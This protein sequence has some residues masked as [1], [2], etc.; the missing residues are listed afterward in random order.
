MTSANDRLRRAREA[1]SSPVSPGVPM[2]RDELA[3]AV[4]TWL[5]Q[6][7]DAG[8]EYAFDAHHLG[9]LERGAV[10]RPHK[11]LR[12]AL[13]AVLQR[14][15]HEL[16]FTPNADGERPA[17]EVS[18]L[19]R[20]DAVRA[21]SDVLA[22][23]RRQ[24]DALG[25]YDVLPAALQQ[26]TIA[27]RIADTATYDTRKRSVSL[28][29]NVENY[30]GWLAL[31]LDKWAESRTH[32]DRAALLAVEA[33]DPMRLSSALSFSAYRAVRRFK[34]TEAASLTEAAQRDERCNPGIRAYLNYQRAE[35][36]GMDG[37]RPEALKVLHVADAL[38]ETIDHT[39]GRWGEPWY[40]VANR[41]LALHAMGDA[42]GARRNAEAAVLHIPQDMHT[43]P[44]RIRQTARRVISL[45]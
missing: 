36:L 32:L 28:V 43:Q 27:E 41:A 14:T 44:L 9:R 22:A 29:A 6:H 24:E 21:V 30:C 26:L 19:E 23:L 37:M 18:G 13:T 42:E 20:T 15:E 5:T 33:D 1:M 2:T 17:E 34:Y 10:R 39:S 12:E 38:A 40:Y 3:A 45:V 4:R 35:I 11:R 8:R 7:D 31:S 16:G 25:A